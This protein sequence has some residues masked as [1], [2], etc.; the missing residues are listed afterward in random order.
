MG[1]IQIV[2]RFPKNKYNLLV[3]NSK[4]LIF[5]SAIVGAILIIALLFIPR[6]SRQ[7]TDINNIVKQTL[8]QAQQKYGKDC[9]LIRFFGT[10]DINGKLVDNKKWYLFFACPKAKKVVSYTYKNQPKFWQE[11]KYYP[12]PAL[13]WQN[14]KPLGEIA[15]TVKQKCQDSSKQN[16]Q[17]SLKFDTK[18]K[19]TYWRVTC[20]NKTGGLTFLHINAQTGEFIKY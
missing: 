7:K 20:K 14:I 15:K 8:K 16:F 9:Y 13:N 1:L 18:T 10:V 4:K 19:I 11:E 17:Y 2:D 3:N 6:I 5:I 12:K